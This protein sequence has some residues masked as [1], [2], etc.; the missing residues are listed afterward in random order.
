MT[1]IWQVSL[2]TP[3]EAAFPLSDALEPFV[4][5]ISVF[6]QEE[7]KSW[8]LK[9]ISTEE[10][11]RSEIVGAL[12]NVA[13]LGGYDLPAIEIGLLPD[14]DWLRLNRESFPAMRFGRFLVHGS[15][16]RG[17]IPVGSLNIEVDAAQ[18]FGSGSHGTT[19]GCLRAIERLSRRMTP[20]NVLDMGCGSGILSMAAAKIWSAARVMAVDIDPIAVKTT[21]ENAVASGVGKRV[22]VRA[23]NGYAALKGRS[24]GSYDLILSNILARPLCKMAPSLNRA[25]KP[26]GAAVL[27][28][29]LYHQTAAVLSAHRQQGLV[30]AGKWRFG[31]W[32]TMML[33]K[34][35][36]A[37]SGPRRQGRACDRMVVPNGRNFGAADLQ[38]REKYPEGR[39]N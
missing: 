24:R 26:G 11:V 18:A 16:L 7:K 6:E 35:T 4:E 12:S 20:L 2:E 32:M 8:I 21:R 27:S 29:L 10:P 37:V 23:G 9:G 39:W 31:D 17:K 33:K 13:T 15:H 3:A 1:P 5:A 25:L 19:E 34:K 14:T 36:G 28:G 38:A 22:A 30:L